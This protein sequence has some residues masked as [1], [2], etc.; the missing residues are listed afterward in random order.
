MD[1]KSRVHKIFNSVSKD[2]DKMNNLISLNQH[3][4]WRKKTMS[5]IFIGDGDKILDICCGTGDWTIQLAEENNNA[6]VTGL[7]F[8]E[9][10]LAIA[11][12]KTAGFKNIELL[13]GDATD[14]PFA[15]HS[16]NLL[17]IGFGL[18]N[19]PD[20]ASAI[21]EFYRVL[22][23]GGQ[24]VILETSIP[25]NKLISTGFNLYFGTIMPFMGGVIAHKK[26][27]YKWLYESTSEFLTKDALLTILKSYDFTNLKVIPHTLGTAATHVAYKPLGDS[28]H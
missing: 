2:Y 25:D 18:R 17:T 16:F 8:S 20:Y 5:E 3:T 21:K 27:E 1:K 24:L 10:M 28:Q 12:E 26:E 22:A 6:E 19:L 14:L 23:P 11:K 13:Q 9:N 4:I 15:D 7:D